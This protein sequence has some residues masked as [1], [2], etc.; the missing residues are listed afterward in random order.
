MGE[1]LNWLVKQ[2]RAKPCYGIFFRQQG[3][4]VMEALQPEFAQ[5]LLSADGQQATQTLLQGLEPQLAMELMQFAVEQGLL[6]PTT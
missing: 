6:L 3:Q 2:L 5:L 4:P 1:K